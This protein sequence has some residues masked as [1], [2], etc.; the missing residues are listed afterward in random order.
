MPRMSGAQAVVATLQAHGVEMVWGIPGVHTL[1]LYDALRGQHTIRHI[2]AR[3]E[4]GAGYM[5]SGYARASGRPGVALT[6]TGP[7]VT[8][9]ATPMAD[10]FTDSIPLLV[11]SSALP[12]DHTGK[13]TG[14][15]HE[16]KSQRGVM[17]AVAG[18]TRAVS[19]MEEIPD[20]L[21]D[22]FRALEWGR[23]R[24]AYLEIPL[25]LF[26]QEADVT[27]PMRQP[28][29]LRAPRPEALDA[30]ASML[31]AAQRPVI[32][33]GA[34]VT[35]AGANALL[36]EVAERLQAPVVLGNKSRDVLPDT[37]PLAI[38]M[39][40]RSAPKELRASIEGAD[41]VLVVGS[42]LSEE[43]IGLRQGKIPMPRALIHIDIDPSE[44][45]H[46]YPAAIG[47]AAD[48]RLALQA[49]RER[50]AQQPAER[51]S[52]VDEVRAARAALQDST[53][54]RYST[55]VPFL[56]AIRAAMPDDGIL[57]ADM[58]YTGYAAGDYFPTSGPRTFIHS[59]ELCTIGC[60]LPMALGAKLAHPDR[61]VVALCGD[62]GFLL[63]TGELAT[64]VQE[65]IGAIAI[66]FNDHAYTAVKSNQRTML[67]GRYMATDLRTPDYVA[68]AR[69]FGATGLRAST[70]DDLAGS[71]AG[72]RHSGGPTLI[73]VPLQRSW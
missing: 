39:A 2:L 50:L 25:D 55:E 51:P 65:G 27:I 17:D 72:A 64:A 69:A 8:N 59:S 66:V 48:A 4:Q 36:A 60:G 46:Q 14:A 52:R 24:G 71:I 10:A 22:A 44:I 70:P 67:G 45:D 33:A 42:K 37:F 7:G 19:H 58:T 43:R 62:G 29:P 11:I 12:R 61:A 47:I 21:R 16:L 38:A 49:L 30:A 34:G 5:A 63:N 28:A 13:R 40:G 20:A 15:L 35:A 1:A 3:H 23:P 41:A 26:E 73:E 18:W 6:I 56:D 54:R 9:V 68:L 31:L 53:R 57:V 32:L